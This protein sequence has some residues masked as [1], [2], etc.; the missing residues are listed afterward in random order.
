MMNRTGRLTWLALAAG[1]LASA[2]DKPQLTWE[3]VVD[4]TAILSVSGNRIGVEN[5]EGAAVARQRYR[6]YGKLP[7]SRQDVRVEVREGRGYVH[8][9][10]QPRL[11]NGYTLRV[12]VEDRQEGASFYSLAFYWN[13]ERGGFATPKDARAGTVPDAGFAARGMLW[14]GRVEGRVRVSVERRRATVEPLGS[15]TVTGERA[16]FARELPRKE[17][18]SAAVRRLR[19]GGRVELVESP[20]SLNHYR[21]VFEIDSSGVGDDYEVEVNW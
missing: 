20:T 4:G 18:R 10:Q 3:G 1:A 11:D 2:Q 13:A 16:D 12:S 8:A 5:R 19:G 21:L 9:I 15:A 14:T 7:D 6:F 17:I